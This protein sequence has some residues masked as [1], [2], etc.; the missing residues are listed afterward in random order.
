MRLR[1]TDDALRARKVLRKS[2]SLQA[3]L[4]EVNAPLCLV[5]YLRCWWQMW[6]V[7]LRI[8]T[9]EQAGV[10]DMIGEALYIQMN[11]NLAKVP[12][13][14]VSRLSYP[15]PLAVLADPSIAILADQRPSIAG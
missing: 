8:Q 9:P 3:V 2:G 4:D 5:A 7:L 6:S 13:S 14:A 15:G 1:Y 11:L 10:Q 12:C